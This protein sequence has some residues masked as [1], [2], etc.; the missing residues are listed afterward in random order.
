MAL[1]MRE[2]ASSAHL[3]GYIERFS[4]V[5]DELELRAAELEMP[6]TNGPSISGARFVRFLATWKSTFG[7]R[8]TG[9]CGDYLRAMMPFARITAMTSQ[10]ANQYH[11]VRATR[12]PE[13]P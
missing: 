11:R 9:A 3:P 10:R 5:A 2:L 12:Q 1:Q 8:A 7:Y 13:A 4:Q 6:A